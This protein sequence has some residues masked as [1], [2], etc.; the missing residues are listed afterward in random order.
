MQHSREVIAAR[1]KAWAA[2]PR[3]TQEEAEH[4][5]LIWNAYCDARDGLPDGATAGKQFQPCQTEVGE[6][7]PH[8]QIVL[9]SY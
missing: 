6:R 5:D 7:V 2:S 1:Y 9:H 4:R 3:G 8:R